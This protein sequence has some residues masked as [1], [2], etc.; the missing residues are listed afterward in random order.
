MS[1]VK[2]TNKTSS[3]LRVGHWQEFIDRERLAS[4]NTRMRSGSIG[5]SATAAATTTTKQQQYNTGSLNRNSIRMK[6]RSAS[7]STMPRQ[8]N[9][10]RINNDPL[11]IVEDLDVRRRKSPSNS[12]E[13]LLPP[14]I[15]ELETL[16]APMKDLSEPLP[17][18]ACGNI[19]SV[20][21]RPHPIWNSSN[22]GLVR[23][24][25]QHHHQR[26]DDQESEI[27]SVIIPPSLPPV[28]S[29]A[30]LEGLP[31]TPIRS[32][33]FPDWNKQTSSTSSASTCPPVP[34]KRTNSKLSLL[35]RPSYLGLNSNEANNANTSVIYA[36][37]SKA[38][39]HRTSLMSTGSS[40]NSSG[41]S[42]SDNSSIPSV[43]G[44]VVPH[45]HNHNS[46]SN[47]TTVLLP[48]TP[49]SKEAET[50]FSWPSYQSH[51][52]QNAP[53]LGRNSPCPSEEHRSVSQTGNLPDSESNASSLSNMYAR[54]QAKRAEGH[55]GD[56]HYMNVLYQTAQQRSSGTPTGSQVSAPR[57]IEVLAD[58]SR[59]SMNV[60][61]VPEIQADDGSTIYS[62]P[63]LRQ[64]SSSTSRLQEV[65]NRARRKLRSGSSGNKK[66]RAMAEFR[67]LMRE[68]ERKRHFRVALNIFNSKPSSG[69]EYLVQRDFLELSPSSVARFLRECDGLSQDKVGEFVGDLRDPFAMKV[70][71]CFMQ[72]F[73]FTALRIDK[74]L[75]LLLANV[76]VP[77]EAQKVERLMEVF[78]RRYVECNPAFGSRRAANSSPSDSAVTLAFA[79]MLLNTDLHAPGV[80]QERRMSQ[81]DFINNLRGVDG[82]GDFDPKLLKSIYRGIKKKEFSGGSDHV[83]QSRA[84]EASL[85]GDSRPNISAEHHR[86]LVCL[87]R[88]YEVLDLAKKKEDDLF[89]HPRDIFLFN[90]MLVISK[91]MTATP[92]KPNHDQGPLYSFR[93]AILLSGLEVTMFHTPVYSHGVQL[94]RKRDEKVLVTLNARSEHDRYKFVMDLQES[95]YEVELMER[96]MGENMMG[97]DTS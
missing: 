77:G 52:P 47:S 32:P 37:V 41:N 20:M 59:S 3:N 96:V 97:G 67:E 22:V 15:K 50:T 29:H 56:S 26:D 11:H 18:A 60:K 65:T 19:G 89:Q 62:V 70:L 68:V 4:L 94:V 63:N 43:S 83:A 84:V 10:H 24:I 40:E 1:G 13:K 14:G 74:A 2:K 48:G 73:D 54:M 61:H 21:P 33:K 64:R 30:V 88:L 78:G 58:R 8:L 28:Q 36:N 92:S 66:S 79:C 7:N 31:R 12:P 86:R 34:P 23:P 51:T 16:Y 87:C 76:R 95:I 27:C 80:K 91:Q 9:R 85:Q 75:R 6:E 81:E 49:S 35:P 39:L 38:M 71:A 57:N 53:L 42:S 25:N 69:I 55:R 45:H 82:G 72:D 5:E 93:D 17:G 44:E 46:S 90:D